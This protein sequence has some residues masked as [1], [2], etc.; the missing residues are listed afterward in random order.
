MSKCPVQALMR[1]LL[2]PEAFT[3]PHPLYAGLR[4]AGA[5]HD[6]PPFGATLT[7]F[8]DV[9]DLLFDRSLKVSSEA[10]MPGSAHA[11]IKELLPDDLAALPAPLFL[12]DD[13][14]HKRLRKL[15]APAFSQK[16]IDALETQISALADE[17]IDA[18]PMQG[19]VEI[20]DGFAAPL[21][22]RIICQILGVEASEAT[23]FRAWSEAVINE[24]HPLAT[25][26]QREA[27]IAAHRELVAYFRHDLT[28]RQHAPGNG[29]IGELARAAFERGDLVEDEAISLC[30]NLLVAGH[31]TTTDL[32]SNLVHLLLENP[33]E[34]AK[35]DANPQLW[36]AAV[37]EA[38]RFE[39][40]TPLLARICPVSG[41]RF[42][43]DF[44]QGEAIN[45]F[46]AAA[47]RDPRAYDEP[48]CFNVTRPHR[49]HLSFGGGA[50]YCLG[51]PLAR[52]EARIAVA[53]LFERAPYMELATSPIVWRRSRSFRGL[54]RLHVRLAGSAPHACARGSMALPVVV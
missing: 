7:R 26:P 47:N 22:A 13:P 9:R 6:A 41:Q 28:R 11:L 15:V 50:H 27:A 20:V 39:P 5:L 17:L 34:R 52:A 37:E 40:P 29:L 10:A 19:A 8:S 42:G 45:V 18:M 3:N 2:G 38:L 31:Y 4:E 21:P 32:I 44:E 30:V 46:I 51:A 33:Q 43:R 12:Q 54:S 23:H 16:S 25:A 14:A 35:L 24:L 48:D 36:P 1:R 53:R 49:P